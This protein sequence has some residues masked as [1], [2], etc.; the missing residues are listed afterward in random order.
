M[1]TFISKGTVNK[2][3]VTRR[4]FSVFLVIFPILSKKYLDCLNAAK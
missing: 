3:K 4:L 2:K 1:K